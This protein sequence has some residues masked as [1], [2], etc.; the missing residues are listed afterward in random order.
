MS[1]D[2]ELLAA[3]QHLVSV[4]GPPAFA[5]AASMLPMTRAIA[6]PMV[7]L[8]GVMCGHTVLHSAVHLHLHQVVVSL[9]NTVH[10]LVIYAQMPQLHPPWQQ[11]QCLLLLS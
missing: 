9:Q 6:V 10:K 2:A 1:G 11:F 7:V 3:S 8:V 4:V 5:A